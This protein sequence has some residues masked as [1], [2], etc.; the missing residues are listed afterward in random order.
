MFNARFKPIFQVI[1][2]NS[3]WHVFSRRS[4]ITSHPLNTPMRNYIRAETIHRSVFAFQWANPGN[5]IVNFHTFQT[6][7]MH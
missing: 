7:L 2:T 5:F 4:S 1:G 6:N 3:F